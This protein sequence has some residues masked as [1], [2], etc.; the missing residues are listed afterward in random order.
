MRGHP[1]NI[2]TVLYLLRA[3]TVLYLLLRAVTVLADSCLRSHGVPSDACMSVHVWIPGHAA[4]VRGAAIDRVPVVAGAIP[5]MDRYLQWPAGKEGE[6]EDGR[7][8]REGR[9]GKWERRERR[10]AGRFHTQVERERA[11]EIER[12]IEREMRGRGRQG[13]SGNDSSPGWTDA[14]NAFNAFNRPQLFLTFLA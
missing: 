11:A 3:V 12:E 4:S 5:G 1:F 6:G 10:F 7:S 2:S 8:G 13:Y 9:E 14:F